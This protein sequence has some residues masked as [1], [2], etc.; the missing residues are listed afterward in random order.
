[1]PYYDY[2]PPSWRAAVSLF[3]LVIFTL[4]VILIVAL[5]VRALWEYLF[6]NLPADYKDP[7]ALTPGYDPYRGVRASKNLI[8]GYQ[9]T[10]TSACSRCFGISA[11]SSME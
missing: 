1:M 10:L 11:R 6:T 5:L 9:M 3:L 8:P 7:E 2:D 4:V